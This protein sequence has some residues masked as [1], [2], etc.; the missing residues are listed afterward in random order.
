MGKAAH[1]LG[2]SRMTL[3]RKLQGLAETNAEQAE[4]AGELL[5][6]A[7]NVVRAYGVAPED[8][9]RAANLKFE[10]RFRAMEAIAARQ[11]NDFASLALD[12]QEALWQDVKASELGKSP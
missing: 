1:L 4:E 2:I 12:Q 8:A 10:R 7:V 6:A 11:G 3:W 5:F 9:L